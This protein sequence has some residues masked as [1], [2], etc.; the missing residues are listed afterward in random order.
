MAD[1]LEEKLGN[2]LVCS[3]SVDLGNNRFSTLSIR[4]DSVPSELAA[5]FAAEHELESETQAALEEYIA[6]NK[7][8]AIPRY[9]EHLEART[10]RKAAEARAREAH[11]FAAAEAAAVAAA[12]LS[13]REPA[14]A[15]P[16][17]SPLQPV[18]AARAPLHRHHPH[19]HQPRPQRAYMRH[20][21]PNGRDTPV[22][23]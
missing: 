9:I 17:V 18:P 12:A 20:P 1:A 16:R 21:H 6:T 3:L 14:P 15:P 5:S 23:K 19:H 10:A 22:Q 4:A 8:R 7:A 11:A 2:A 13:P